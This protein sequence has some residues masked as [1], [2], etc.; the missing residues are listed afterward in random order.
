MNEKKRLDM[1][2]GDLS[3]R[4]SVRTTFR[5]SEQALEALGWLSER[6]GLSMKDVLHF[7][8]D[9]LHSSLEQLI[10]LEQGEQIK[11][12]EI[13]SVDDKTIRR[14][15]VITRKTLTLLNK[16]SKQYN[17]TR[18]D[19]L[20]NRAIMFTK[21]LTCATDESKIKAYREAYKLIDNIYLEAGGI[22]SKLRELLGDDNHIVSEFEMGVTVIMGAHIKITEDIEK[23]EKSLS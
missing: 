17:I 12:V 7:A 16:L 9:A 23:I 10:N 5:F 21:V 11:K 13:R 22:E 1:N 2:P 20:I 3:D 4:Q 15:V 8:L 6:Y 14:T 18:R 19:D